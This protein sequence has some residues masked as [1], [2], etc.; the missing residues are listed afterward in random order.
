MK[1]DLALR[2]IEQPQA[3]QSDVGGTPR[4]AG[5]SVSPFR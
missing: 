5:L 2:S 4:R 3:S 1:M